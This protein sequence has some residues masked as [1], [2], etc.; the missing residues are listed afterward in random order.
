M[1]NGN[2]HCLESERG[3]LGSMLLDPERV[4]P[5]TELSNTD[6]YIV[7]H[8]VLYEALKNMYMN[9]C[10]IDTITIK[11]Y[12]K[13][14]KSLEQCGG[15][16]YLL[17]LQ[18]SIVVSSHSQ[19]YAKRVKELSELRNEL[20]IL[21]S[22]KDMV[23]QGKS[24]SD[25]IMSSLIR[26]TTDNQQQ[27][28]YELGEEW[29]DKVASGNT[30]HLNWWCAEWDSYLTKLSSEVCIIHA[31]RSTGKTAWL[32]Q[33]ICYLHQQG[34][35]CSFAS[36]EMI[37]QELLPRLIAHLGQINTYNMRTRGFIKEHERQASL[38]AN[39]KLRGLNLNVRDGSM[40]IFQL[41][42]WALSEK[43]KGADAIF[44]DNLLCIN[45]GGR[46]YVNRT[47]MYDYFI[48]QIIDLRNDIKI[49]IF[50]LAHPNADHGVSYSKNIEN[51]CDI[52]IYLHN[53][54]SEGIDVE[55]KTIMPRMDIPG[56]TVCCRFQKNR[57]GRSPCALLS[58]D[59]QTQT[60]KHLSWE[61]E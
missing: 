15:D 4:I 29:I 10:T 53:V 7:K 60:F 43:K 27:S 18:D 19:A 26:K 41:R 24:C 30:G 9:N 54:P 17:D 23:Y 55:G 59:K 33:Y 57:Q 31:P 1:N 45:D 25:F 52:I 56:D 36:I 58:L 61:I 8:Q 3:I 37:K 20:D 13:D 28:I 5:K 42:S 44:I 49:P 22:G 40:N 14:N 6:F 16:D 32:L 46:N 11:N 38:K 34:L 50:L 12:L 48:Q 51:L 47:A 39:E 2:P 21:E 35:K